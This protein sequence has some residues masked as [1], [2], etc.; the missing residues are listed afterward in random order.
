MKKKGETMYI[1]EDL[2]SGHCQSTSRMWDLGKVSSWVGRY[3]GYGEV[4]L[5]RS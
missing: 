1:H 5:G 4:G 2:S 3:V